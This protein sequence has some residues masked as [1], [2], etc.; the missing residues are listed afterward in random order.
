MSTASPTVEP[1]IAAS[2]PRRPSGDV[3]DGMTVRCALDVTAGIDV[4]GIDVAGINVCGG[5]VGG[6]SGI[7][8][9][10]SAARHAVGNPGAEPTR[11]IAVSVAPGAG[12]VARHVG[13]P[14]RSSCSGSVRRTWPFTVPPLLVWLSMPP[15][16]Q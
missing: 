4:A 16:G 15:D 1:A 13:S 14:S 10:G 5:T 2:I 7:D 11:G 12:H 6:A 8:G 9:D 3:V